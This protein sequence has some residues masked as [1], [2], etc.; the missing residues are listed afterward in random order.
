MGGGKW[1]VGRPTKVPTTTT[2]GL[3]VGCFCTLT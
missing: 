2:R 3:V 1:E